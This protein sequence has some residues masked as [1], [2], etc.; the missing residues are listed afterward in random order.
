M[1]A[2]ERKV[3]KWLSVRARLRQTYV[4]GTV[5]RAGRAQ[6][7]MAIDSTPTRATCFE[8]GMLVSA[9]GCNRGE[10]KTRSV[11]LFH[12]DCLLD[13]L[14]VRVVPAAS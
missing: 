8:W 6:H 9:R 7:V 5:V 2:N 12:W 11:D 10:R 13:Y 4:H 3:S 14:F 1:H